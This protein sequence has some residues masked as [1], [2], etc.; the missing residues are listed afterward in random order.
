[1]PKPKRE[2]K[3]LAPIPKQPEP[4]TDLRRALSRNKK[5]ALVDMLI[6]L[7]QADRGV[8]RQLSTRFEEV[9]TPEELVTRTLQAISD[10][11]A[12]D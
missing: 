5:S 9:T 1:M 11:T 10:A 7:A 4:L 12:F 2:P 8:L 6:E 3:R